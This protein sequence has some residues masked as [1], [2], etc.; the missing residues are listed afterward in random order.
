MF[1]LYNKK[2]NKEPTNTNINEGLI[3]KN[4]VNKNPLLSLDETELKEMCR[5]RIDS[6]EQWSRRLIDETLRT[7]YGKNYIDV[8][9]QEGQPLIKSEIKKKIAARIKDNPKRYSRYI[10]AT[11]MED[12]EYFFCRDDLYKC[13]FKEIF[14][15]YFSGNNEIRSVLRRLTDIR[16]KISHGNLLSIHEV[17]QVFCYTDDFIERFKA[18]YVK[19]GKSRE[20]NVPVFTR[21]KDSFSHDIIRE[22]MECYP[23]E[24]YLTHESILDRPRV[25]LRSGETYKL[26]VEVDS[27][28]P[29][30]TYD[31]TWRFEC[32]DRI[33]EGKSN[34]VEVSFDDKDVSYTFEIHF[35][36]KTHNTWHRRARMDNDD[37]L[38]I[39]FSDILPSIESTY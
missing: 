37:E 6:F 8:V 17:E 2:S 35:Y 12:I 24:L 7:N 9:I 10:D 13:Y 4:I 39:S 38:I 21:V 18:Y 19:K 25:V 22:Y 27:S 31:V 23:W 34:T 28:F 14:E 3:R 29:E 20:Y 5:H 32:G 26:W 15:P 30:N 11:V 16:N 1:N 33:E 36:L